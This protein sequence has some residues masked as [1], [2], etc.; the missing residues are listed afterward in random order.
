[1]LTKCYIALKYFSY[2]YQFRNLQSLSLNE[3]HSKQTLDHFTLCIKSPFPCFNRI[4]YI[5]QR[6]RENYFLS[7]QLCIA[8]I[9]IYLSLK[10]LI[11]IDYVD[12]L[13]NF[14][15]KTPDLRYLNRSIER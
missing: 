10:Y 11:L 4:E 6:K 12:H 13:I 9:V 7:N 8:S 14:C 15:E 1:V 2:E 3:I 5:S